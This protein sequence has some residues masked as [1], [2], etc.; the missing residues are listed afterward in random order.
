VVRHPAVSLI[1]QLINGEFASM[2]V[3]KPKVSILTNVNAVPQ[4]SIIVIFFVSQL[5]QS[6]FSKF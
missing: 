3:S 6:L 1:R 2:H 4:L 5:N